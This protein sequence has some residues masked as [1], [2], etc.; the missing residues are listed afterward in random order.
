MRVGDLEINENEII[1]AIG[2]SVVTEF[3][4]DCKTEDII[5]EIIQN[6]FDAESPKTIIKFL[7]DKLVIEG[8][9]KPVNKE[10]WGRLKSIL[11]YG[12]LLGTD[13]EAKPKKSKLGIKNQGLRTL[14]RLG[15]HI[16]IHSKGF[17]NVLLWNQGAYGKPKKDS[18]FKNKKGIKIEVPYRTHEDKDLK[19]FDINEEKRLYDIIKERLP[20]I[21]IKLPTNLNNKILE[22]VEIV[23]ERLGVKLTCSL[24]IEKN[25]NVRSKRLKSFIRTLNISSLPINN[26]ENNN[27]KSFRK[28]YREVEYFKTILD[29]EYLD[30]DIPNYYCVSKKGK[31]KRYIM[32]GFSFEIDNKN[33]IKFNRFGR[34]FYP[35][36]IQNEFS[37]NFINISAPFILDSTRTAISNSKFNEWLIENATIMLIDLLRTELIHTFGPKA[38]D[39]FLN[40]KEN[41]N[42]IFESK[43]NEEFANSCCILNDAYKMNEKITP[44]KFI[45]N[46]GYIPTYEEKSMIFKAL[47]FYTLVADKYETVS[48]HISDDFI[49][50][51]LTNLENKIERL[52]INNVLELML[53]DEDRINR[54]E[55]KGW[56]VTD[57]FKRRFENVKTQKQFLNL[58]YEYQKEIDDHK[59]EDLLTSKSLL[60]E[61]GALSIW[62]KMFLFRGKPADFIGFDKGN[63][64]HH[65]LVNLPFFKNRIIKKAIGSYNINQEITERYLPSIERDELDE[66]ERR[67]LLKFII[68]NIDLINNS[69]L[70]EIKKYELFLDEN[71]NSVRFND[72]IIPDKNIRKAFKDSLNYPH[73]I[74]LLDNQM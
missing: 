37:G 20:M 52:A 71:N 5:E 24:K 12:R 8:F 38:Y 32:I 13:G 29:G 33:N 66:I 35:I 10:G 54:E 64:V 36:G 28:R 30:Q 46:T 40:C 2:E 73:K 11:G 3:R 14:F 42:E 68:S 26:S 41:G 65:E 49:R 51:I 16:I 17:F 53:N 69:C 27:I 74:L 1:F 63:I 72:L 50:F 56:H 43:I 4:R 19:I 47:D 15:D 44:S 21:M 45:K 23:F 59:L 70:R 55:V 18:S 6:D 22:R 62:D 67:K 7:E 34:L 61:K 9:G 57:N 25:L 58:F 31:D 60:S 39:L 48:R